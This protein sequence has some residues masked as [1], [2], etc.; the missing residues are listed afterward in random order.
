[1]SLIVPEVSD[2]CMKWS[3][4]FPDYTGLSMAEKMGMRVLEKQCD[5][6]WEAYED[7]CE[8]DWNKY[9]IMVDNAWYAQTGVDW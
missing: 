8:K 1:M 9:C 2:Y 4:N 7:Y 6:E 3:S 5:Q